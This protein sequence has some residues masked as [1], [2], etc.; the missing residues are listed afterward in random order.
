M[1]QKAVCFVSCP[2]DPQAD[3]AGQIQGLW[4]AERQLDKQGGMERVTRMGVCS[5][6][7]RRLHR[8]LIQGILPV[9]GGSPFSDWLYV[10]AF[11]AASANGAR[12]L[13]AIIHLLYGTQHLPA[14]AEYWRMALPVAAHGSSDLSGLAMV[15]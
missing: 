4:N 6:G 10:F 7:G 9:P 5:G 11:V 14:D 1:G 2:P 13:D 3:L 8:R 15:Y 12:G